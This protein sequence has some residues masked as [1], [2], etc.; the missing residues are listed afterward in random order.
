[1]SLDVQFWYT[2]ASKVEGLAIQAGRII[3]LTDQPGYFYDMDD[4]TGT[5]HRYRVNNIEYVAEL[6]TDAMMAVEADVSVDT[7][8]ILNVMYITEDGIWRWK[9]SDVEGQVGRWQSLL[10]V[11]VKEAPDDGFVYSRQRAPGQK[12]TW[13]KLRWIFASDTE[14]LASAI[15]TRIGDLLASAAASIQVV[16][17]VKLDSNL[18]VATTAANRMFL[19]DLKDATF[20]QGATGALLF[21]AAEGTCIEV[22]GNIGANATVKGKGE[23]KFA[24]CKLCGDISTE[25]F[26][27]TLVVTECSGTGRSITY[28]RNITPKGALLVSGCVLKGG[29]INMPADDYCIN[30]LNNNILVGVKVTRGGDNAIVDALYNNEGGDI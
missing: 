29:D 6:P 3:A 8:G 16:G 28:S 25:S 19:L 9:R 17:T 24:N 2:T 14:M 30:L 5:V 23:I 11:D 1:M 27:G 13:T 4:G 18:G 7:Q 20:S 10:P 21:D 12:G 15:N 26:A 22:C